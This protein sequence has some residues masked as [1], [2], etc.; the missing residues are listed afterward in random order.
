MPTVEEV[1]R[2]LKKQDEAYSEAS[3]HRRAEEVIAREQ[4]AERREAERAEAEATITAR[5]AALE[6]QYAKTEAALVNYIEAREQL[7]ATRFEYE[8]AWRRANQ[9]EVAPVRVPTFRARAA[10][11]DGTKERHLRTRAAQINE[12]SW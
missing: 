10:R 2:T 4:A 9:F 3:L 7:A 8:A 11:I 6:K 12:A 1:A 5:T